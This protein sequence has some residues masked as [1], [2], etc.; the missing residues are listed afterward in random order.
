MPQFLA[1]ADQ[2]GDGVGERHGEGAADVHV[3]AAR[4]DDRP[5]A[6]AHAVERLH[7]AALDADAEVRVERGAR[8]TGPIG[9]SFYGLG[10][11]HWLIGD[12]RGNGDPVH[13]SA[14]LKPLEDRAGGG[15][16]HGVG[17]PDGDTMDVDERHDV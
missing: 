17:G 12:Q 15:Q 9:R 14:R 1:A 6:G 7:D 4:G 3:A 13:L 8:G 16:L 11:A 2:R 10:V 5:R